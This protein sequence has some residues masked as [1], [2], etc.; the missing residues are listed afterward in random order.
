MDNEFVCVPI[1]HTLYNEFS[2]RLGR[3]TNP[4][5]WIE[6][7]V[8][9]Y[10]SRTEGDVAIWGESHAER[11]RV[12]ETIESISDD[13]GPPD[14]GFVWGGVLLNNGSRLRMK[15]KGRYEYASIRH[16]QI[17]Y[18]ENPVSP[19][20]FASQ[21]AGGTN[22]NAWRDIEIQFPHQTEGVWTPVDVL[23]K[24]PITRPFG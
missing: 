12:R 3:S 17:I 21:V 14:R 11:V 15:Y 24:R 8:Q 16:A 5:S 1:S 22:R 9:D 2:L 18:R 10:L 6:N 19:S 13:A 4:A 20:E 23:R 7:I